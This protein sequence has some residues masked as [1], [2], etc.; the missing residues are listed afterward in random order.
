MGMLSQVRKC[1]GR[2]WQTATRAWH[3][4]AEHDGD[5]RTQFHPRHAEG[6]DATPD[7]L[8]ARHGARW[9]ILAAEV[10][11]GD[12][13][14]EIDIEVPGMDAGDFE[15]RVVDDVLTV[16]GEKKIQRE[17]TQGRFHVMERAYGGF[18]RTVRMPVPVDESGAQARYERGVLHVVLPRG[19]V[20]KA[21]RIEVEQG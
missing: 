15:I 7:E 4:L 18:E 3:G 9:G 12:D 16:R 8:A 1:L 17:R 14:V 19:E 20:H 5:G 13:T 21:R 6:G 2:A 11:V 10:Q